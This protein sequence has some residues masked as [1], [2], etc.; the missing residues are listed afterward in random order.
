MILSS[1]WGQVCVV[2]RILLTGSNGYIGSVLGPML[3]ERG[4]NVVGYDSNPYRQNI[5]NIVIPKIPCIVKNI[6]D[7]TR[8]D[9]EGFDAICH[10]AGLPN[11]PLR[12][13]DSELF[14]SIN[15]HASIRLAKLAQESHLKRYIFSS[16]CS[17]YGMAGNDI[18]TEESP[19]N[20]LT[21]YAISKAMVEQNVSKMAN[22]RF[23]PTFLRL[24]TAYGISPQHRFDLIINNMVGLALVTGEIRMKINSD[25]WR[26]ILHVQDISRAFTAVLEA[27]RDQIHNE[28]FNVGATS[29]NFRIKDIADII[30]HAIPDCKIIGS[31]ENKMDK[32]NYRV[33]CDKFLQNFPLFLPQWDI[34]RG[35]EELAI[36]YRKKR[37]TK[38]MLYQ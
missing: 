24:S 5:F 18:L 23:S 28:I 11:D 37:L 2:M 4:H 15:N 29:A 26:P 8:E 12:R 27:E 38:E 21:P 16:S 13:I 1:A 6:L 9:L 10:L 19:L 17:I 3:L 33:S 30:Y 20:P 35:I 34:R 7:I 14:F 36:F 25:F 32:R 31:E 22:D